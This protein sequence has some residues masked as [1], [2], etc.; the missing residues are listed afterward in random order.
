MKR[1]NEIDLIVHALSPQYVHNSVRQR[2]EE[3]M[4]HCDY[5]SDEHQALNPPRDH[6]VYLLRRLYRAGLVRYRDRTDRAAL[7]YKL[8]NNCYTLMLRE[9]LISLGDTPRVTFNRC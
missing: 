3:I 7:A 1:A 8:V 6:L 9:A 4:P 2:I 5:Y